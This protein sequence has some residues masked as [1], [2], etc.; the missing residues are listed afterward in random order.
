MP[1]APPNDFDHL[2]GR[3]VTVANRG[4]DGTKIRQLAGYVVRNLREQ[5]LLLVLGQRGRGRKQIRVQDR[6]ANLCEKGTAIRQSDTS[7]IEHSETVLK[8]C[9][10]IHGAGPS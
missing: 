2:V 1:Q 8:N 4:E 3:R 6:I 10:R 9:P 5:E 7:P